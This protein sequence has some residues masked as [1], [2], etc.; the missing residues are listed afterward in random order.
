MLKSH[1]VIGNFSPEDVRILDFD[2]DILE[3]L[4]EDH[5]LY[6]GWEV[7]ERCLGGWHV[8]WKLRIGLEEVLS[9]CKMFQVPKK[10]VCHSQGS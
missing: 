7:E 9:N 1:L 10:S 2:S 5:E 4:S 3:V 8:V 6:L